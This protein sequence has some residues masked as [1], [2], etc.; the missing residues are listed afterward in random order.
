MVDCYKKIVECRNDEGRPIGMDGIQQ[1]IM[2]KEV[3]NVK[4]LGRVFKKVFQV[5]SI[6]ITEGTQSTKLKIEDYP[7]L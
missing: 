5:L 2:I 6:H 3:S 4:H 7:L 1:P